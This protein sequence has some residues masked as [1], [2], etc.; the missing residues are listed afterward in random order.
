MNIQHCRSCAAPVN[1]PGMDLTGP[2]DGYC[3]Y[4]ITEDGT[5]KPRE[6]IRTQMKHWMR[7]AW[8]LPDDAELEQRVDAY[9]RAMPHW[10]Q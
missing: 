3:K 2:L 9:M 7:G 5:V 8:D 1:M 4:C 6:Q 10:S